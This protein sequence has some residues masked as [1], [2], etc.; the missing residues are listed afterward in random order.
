M[1]V[2][3]DKVCSYTNPLS[4]PTE[5]GGKVMMVAQNGDIVSIAQERAVEYRL[6]G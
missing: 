1:Q 4:S 5:I 2:N 6:G 3:Y